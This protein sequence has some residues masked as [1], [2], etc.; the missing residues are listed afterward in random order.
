M[1]DGDHKARVFISYSRKDAGIAEN[2][3]E[4]LNARNFEAYL[5][6]HEILPGEPWQERLAGL[7][8]DADC[9]IF[10]LTPASAAS[11]ICDWEVNE[12]ERLGKRI[13]PVIA[14]SLEQNTVPRRLQRLNFIFMRNEAER[15]REMGTLDHAILTDID[16]VREHTRIGEV[17][18]RWA[19]AGEDVKSPLLLRGMELEAAEAWIA[20]RPISA[21]DTT[22]DQR[23]FIVASRSAATRRQRVILATVTFLAAVGFALFFAAAWQRSVAVAQR[24][25]ALVTQSRFLAS[26][27]ER[28]SQHNENVNAML[29]A[30]EGL[31]DTQEGRI[32][33]YDPAPT[34]AAYRALAENMERVVL[35]R[36]VHWSS[37]AAIFTP[38]GLHVITSGDPGDGNVQIWSAISGALVREV[39]GF[40][41]AVLSP[42]Q[43]TLLTGGD[44][45]GSARLWD[46]NN[47]HVPPRNLVPPAFESVNHGKGVVSAAFSPDGQRVAAV[48]NG[49]VAALWDAET[50]RL[51]AALPLGNWSGELPESD[52]LIY[53]PPRISFSTSGDRILT[54]TGTAG[55]R[56]WDGNTGAEVANLTGA[57]CGVFMP[58]GAAVVTASNALRLWDANT[59]QLIKDH[60]AESNHFILSVAVS[61]DG[62]LIATGNSRG[63][64]DVWDVGRRT[65]IDE[66]P[67]RAFAH[68][69]RVLSLQ[70][71]PDGRR[72]L[73]ASQD[74]EEKE[75]AAIIWN[76][77]EGKVAKSLNSHL[78]SVTHARFNHDSTWIATQSV[79]GTTR[80]WS[81]PAGKGATRITITASGALVDVMFDRSGRRIIALDTENRIGIASIETPSGKTVF[82]STV[83][84]AVPTVDPMHLVRPDRFAWGPG[85]FFRV[86]S[87][88]IVRLA[89]RLEREAP[90]PFIDLESLSAQSAAIRRIFAVNRN[91]P[92]VVRLRDDRVLAVTVRSKPLLGQFV[93][94]DGAHIVAV[95]SEQDRTGFII[96]QLGRFRE[97]PFDAAQRNASLSNNGVL[98]AAD[99]NN[100]PHSYAEVREDSPRGDRFVVATRTGDATLF[101]VATGRKLAIL[102][103]FPCD[104]EECI[105]RNSGRPFGAKFSQD[106]R[107]VVTSSDYR[108]ARVYDADNGALLTELEN[109]RAEG[110]VHAEFNPAGDRV[111]TSSLDRDVWLWPLF[112]KTE[113][114]ITQI[115]SAAPR[116]LTPKE[117][118]SVFLDATPPEWCVIMK[119]WPYESIAWQEWLA[120]RKRGEDAGQPK[121]PY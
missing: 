105:S 30:E 51:I 57:T 9:I 16:W 116:C 26:A 7:I 64:I 47:P 71:S 38:D 55:A 101:E 80:L 4:T 92:I 44:T 11:P 110:I 36:G 22:E 27:A 77:N 88:E 46:W 81:D 108:A 31:P 72:L 90:L 76:V 93:S 111:L 75:H 107:F 25:Q 58:D 98:S 95:V 37:D 29:V 94:P 120:K 83:R 109:A 8:A 43:R 53:I 54:L 41:V 6:K 67:W 28:F 117:R 63:L 17:T 33:P 61:P 15:V 99:Q 79:D 84:V 73:S 50:G 86:Y 39:P 102:K 42:D 52:G 40:G 65:V 32:R 114:L 91:A 89:Q 5:D 13:L 45:P 48:W 87:D 66:K 60:F 49:T 23:R 112:S 21:P 19:R 68:A 100:L 14:S 96:D 121:V 59:G 70:F 56:L 118:E 2:L 74:L 115:K 10:L 3:R 12:A 85:R 103:G 62:K 106:G 34:R 113:D 78:G 35:P 69:S 82:R 97:T 1:A 24:D 104:F 20:A 18:N 119:K